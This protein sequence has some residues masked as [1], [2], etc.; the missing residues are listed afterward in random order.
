MPTRGTLC[1]FKGQKYAEDSAG[2]EAKASVLLLR[3]NTV[4][5]CFLYTAFFQGPTFNSDP[6]LYL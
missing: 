3:V 6:D 4:N 1:E 2:W 5:K